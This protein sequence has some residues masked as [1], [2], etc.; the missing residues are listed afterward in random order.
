M[1]HYGKLRWIAPQKKIRW[2][3]SST[4][5]KKFRPTSQNGRFRDFETEPETPFWNRQFFFSQNLAYSYNFSGWHLPGIN[6]SLES[7]H[8]YFGNTVKSR[9]NDEKFGFFDF[10]LWSRSN[11]GIIATLPKSP[12]NFSP[13]KNM[14]NLFFHKKKFRPTSQ[15]GRFPILTP[16]LRPL[17]GIEKRFFLKIQLSRIVF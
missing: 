9:K 14:M 6:M 11:V 2:T 3:F 15:N 16:K 7:L 5:K 8:N 4:K 17:S 13:K 10:F 12:V 1:Q